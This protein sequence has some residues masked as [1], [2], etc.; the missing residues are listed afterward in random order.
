MSE[1]PFCSIFTGQSEASLVYADEAT[2]AFLDLRQPNGGH[3]LVA[4]RQHI[5]TRYDL[6][7]ATGA[8]LMRT[9]VR[10]AR[11]VRTS[12]QP[13]GMSIW[14]SNGEAAGQEVPHVHFHVLARQPADGLLRVYA[15]KPPRP[16][17][18]ALNQLAITIQ[19]AFPTGHDGGE[20]DQDGGA[21]EQRR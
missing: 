17:R 14:Q 18:E 12:L 16:E 13:A 1:C 10:T 19:H 5:Q 3:V 9:V 15:D 20:Q 7:E 2:I 4:P 11:A 21:K 8:A 6:D